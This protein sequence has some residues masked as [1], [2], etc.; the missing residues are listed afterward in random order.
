MLKYNPNLKK[1]AQDNRKAG[2]LSEALLWLQLKGTKMKYN[3][4]RQKP[5]GNYIVDFFC[6][7]LNLV[8]EIDGVSHDDKRESDVVRETYLKSLGLNLIRFDDREIK[9]QMDS[10]LEFIRN[11]VYDIEHGKRV[12]NSI[13]HEKG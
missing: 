4:H 11:T 1:Y 12:F 5:I 7:K 13:K 9:L 2:N 10:V 6:P 3:F 8:I